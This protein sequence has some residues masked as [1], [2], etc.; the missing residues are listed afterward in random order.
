MDEDRKWETENGS[1]GNFPKSVYRSLIV[2]TEFAVC[3]FVEEETNGSYQFANRLDGLN[4]RA[5][6]CTYAAHTTIMRAVWVAKAKPA[7]Q[8]HRKVVLSKM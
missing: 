8:L 7:I 1:P 6:L 4:G 2:Q 3:S 5:Y